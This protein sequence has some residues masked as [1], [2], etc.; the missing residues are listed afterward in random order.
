MKKLPLS[1]IK[2]RKGKKK[3]SF[4]YKANFGECSLNGGRAEKM[5]T[6]DTKKEVQ[7][8]FDE[9][10]ALYYSNGKTLL[11]RNKH[12]FHQNGSIKTFDALIALWLESLDLKPATITGYRSR[13]RCHISPYIGKYKIGNLTLTDLQKAID[14]IIKELA[15]K[16]DVWERVIYDYK[17]L[18]T[19]AFK[20]KLISNNLMLAVDY[21]IKKT[22]KYL[23][24]LRIK[25]DGNNIKSYDEEQLKK[26]LATVDEYSK[27]N[28]YQAPC[29]TIYIK[30]LIYSGFRPSEALALTWG[31]VDFKENTIRINK[32]ISDDDKTIGTPKTK[33][34]NRTIKISA[35]FMQELMK[36]EHSQL[37]FWQVTKKNTKPKYIFTNMKN[38][39]Q[40]NNNNEW[41][42][43]KNFRK[44][45]KRICEQNNIQYFDGSP[46]H[47]FRHTHATTQLLNS[48]HNY[49]VKFKIVSKRLGHSDVFETIKTYHHLF[50]EQESSFDD[51]FD[52][53]MSS[54]V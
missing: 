20:R 40:R 26:I 23:D 5:L 35:S 22:K 1:K 28:S 53:Y 16:C 54:L 46:L 39:M 25:T 3:I 38:I 44:L 30:M 48:K 12:N 2:T 17:N 21:D 41:Y 19:F 11:D 7:V 42:T 15:P 45:W 13:A 34:S 50:P 43:S 10:Q 52:L 37:L 33:S 24:S 6:G 31:D 29:F 4:Y 14:K 32:T 36:F 9:Q 49:E 51:E 27:N 18:F 8:K 47:C